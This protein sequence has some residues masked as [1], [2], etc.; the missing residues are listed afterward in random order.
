MAQ[1]D[2]DAGENRNPE[3]RNLKLALLL[4]NKQVSAEVSQ[5]GAVRI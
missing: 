1:S 3:R 5:I 4:V 2:I